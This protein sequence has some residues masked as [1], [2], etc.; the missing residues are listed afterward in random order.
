M[1]NINISFDVICCAC[2]TGATLAGLISGLNLQQRA[3][4]VAV[5]KGATFLEQEVATLLSSA[6]HLPYASWQI[7]HEYHFGGYAKVNPALLNFVDTFERQHGVPIEP[8][9]TGKLLYAI[10]DKISQGEFKR[11]SKIVILHSGGLQSRAFL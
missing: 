1:R 8:I 7:A 2:G 5:L 6:S 9:Y 10:Y 3:I 4:G 11:G